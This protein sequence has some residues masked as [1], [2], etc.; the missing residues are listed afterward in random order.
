MG[1][2]LDQQLGE[3]HHDLGGT[4]PDVATLQL[5]LRRAVHLGVPVAEDVRTPGAHEVDILVVVHVP[6]AAAFGAGE[7]L[8][9]ARP[10]QSR[11][12]VA[13]DAVGDHVSGALQEGR[14]AAVG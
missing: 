5:R 12:H 11:G 10:D 7:E 2:G 6:D 4:V 8:W 13:P 1:H 9:I 3:F 14:V